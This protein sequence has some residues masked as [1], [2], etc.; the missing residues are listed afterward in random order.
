MIILCRHCGGYINTVALELS[1]RFFYQYGPANTCS[2]CYN[3]T[4]DEPIDELDFVRN[5][6]EIMDL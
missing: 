6:F 2:K 1:D 3:K 4:A 5:R